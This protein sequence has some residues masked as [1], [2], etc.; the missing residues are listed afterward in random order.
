MR[1]HG[2]I[3]A[4]W[5]AHKVQDG[6]DQDPA[7]VVRQRHRVPARNK[8]P[9][10]AGSTAALDAPARAGSLLS[11]DSTAFPASPSGLD[12][13]AAGLQALEDKAARPSLERDA[14]DAVHAMI[15]SPHGKRR[16]ANGNAAE[17]EVLRHLHQLNS[18]MD[19]G[20]I[21]KLFH[22]FDTNNSG[23]LEHDQALAF[24]DAMA[25]QWYYHKD[26][27]H[28]DDAEF[29]LSHCDANKSGG[30][31]KREMMEALKT[32]DAYMYQ[33]DRVDAIF[34]KYDKNRSGRLEREQVLHFLEDLASANGEGTRVTEEELDYVMSRAD[35]TKT[36]SLL[37]ME[38]AMGSAAF[39]IN[40]ARDKGGNRL[41]M[42]MRDRVHAELKRILEQMNPALFS[43]G[44]DSFLEDLYALM[45]RHDPL[46][47][48]TK[49]EVRRVLMAALDELAEAKKASNRGFGS[50]AAAVEAMAQAK[51]D[52]DGLVKMAYPSEQERAKLRQLD[53]KAS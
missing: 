8:G 6:M 16:G 35:V 43:S 46:Q 32:F 22:E 9:Q 40:R 7:E 53:L 28:T 41:P 31:C 25:K 34:A 11:M 2:L 14:K 18:Q 39:L 30:I 37:K 24:F 51:K 21:D 20:L 12:R 47:R 5:L 27:A 49:D 36:G 4:N 23:E 26:G 29:V 13:K 10:R 44:D 1:H 45:C 17:S 42:E 50:P 38:V 19:G 33:R 52:V 15:Q 3:S 48:K